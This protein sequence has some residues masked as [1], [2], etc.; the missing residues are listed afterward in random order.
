NMLIFHPIVHQTKAINQLRGEG[1][2]IPDEILTYVAPYWTEHYNRY[3]LFQ[4]NM[5]RNTVEI[6]Y[7]FI[8]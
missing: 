1:I 7:D 2:E 5:G 3:G 8:T 6:E 4:L